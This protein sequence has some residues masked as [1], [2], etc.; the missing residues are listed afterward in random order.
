MSEQ[1]G[2]HSNDKGRRPGLVKVLVIVVVITIVSVFV[3]I[4]LESHN[5]SSPKVTVHDNLSSESVVWNANNQDFPI[6]NVTSFF[7]VS[8][9]NGT[10][11]SFTLGIAPWGGMGANG[12]AYYA[13]VDVHGLISKSFHPTLIAVGV[14]SA[15]T[16][17]ADFSS[18]GY[19]GGYQPVPSLGWYRDNTTSDW[20]F[21][22]T[23]FAQFPKSFSIGTSAS[24]QNVSKGGSASP[25]FFSF[26]MMLEITVNATYDAVTTLHYYAFIEGVGTNV[27]AQSTLTITD[28]Y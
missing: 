27:S 6:M 14:D 9:E 22:N 26:P 23:S 13:L 25:Y 1:H 19:P 2:G 17:T 12:A 10:N 24:L 5:P 8:A 28:H 7:Q 21:W 11:S 3:V 18:V 20:Y 16:N 15:G 4:G